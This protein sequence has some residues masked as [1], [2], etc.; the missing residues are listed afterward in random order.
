MTLGLQNS[1][2]VRFLGCLGIEIAFCCFFPPLFPRILQEQV[3]GPVFDTL[4]D[5]R[6]LSSLVICGKVASLWFRLLL[7][8]KTW[9]FSGL[10]YLLLFE[11]ASVF[12]VLFC[13]VL[14]FFL[15]GGLLS[16]GL[17]FPLN[18]L[19]KPLSWQLSGQ[20]VSLCL[21]SLPW[22]LRASKVR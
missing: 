14:F 19:F 13:F 16:Y 22:S 3:W 2:L 5:P 17:P 8:S 12:F 9:V 18:S 6:G 11:M 21:L 4:S 7:F 20:C 15:A 10:I 1:T